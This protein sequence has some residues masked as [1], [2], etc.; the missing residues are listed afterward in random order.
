MGE[1]GIAPTF[2]APAP[3][4]EYRNSQIGSAGNSRSV[5][6]NP[7]VAAPAF[8]YTAKYDECA[9]FSILKLGTRNKGARGRGEGGPGL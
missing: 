2:V 6:P 4:L 7:F 1:E 9:I 3:I 8:S 5:H